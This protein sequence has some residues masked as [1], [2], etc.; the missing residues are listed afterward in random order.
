[1]PLHIYC[2]GLG[3]RT[4]NDGRLRSGDWTVSMRRAQTMVG[5][6][7]HLHKGKKKS[8]HEAYEITG[9]E[10]SRLTGRVV[11][12]LGKQCGT[13]PAPEKWPRRDYVFTETDPYAHLVEEAKAT[14]GR[15]RP[16]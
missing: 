14:S 13:R 3:I 10:P 15:V 1:M 2:E 5:H 7:L 11:F 16:G 8:S 12:I 6:V 4:G 9:V